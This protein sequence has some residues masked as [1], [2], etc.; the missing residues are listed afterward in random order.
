M[1]K[2]SEINPHLR[3]RRDLHAVTVRRAADSSRFEGA[4]LTE[5][6][7]HRAL[8]SNAVRKKSVKGL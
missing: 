5:E 6:S 7:I 8:L 2:L 4:R 3:Q 1:A